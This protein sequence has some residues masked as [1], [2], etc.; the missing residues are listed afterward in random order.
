MQTFYWNLHAF[1]FVILGVHGV[2]GYK[3]DCRIGRLTCVNAMI[4]TDR[5]PLNGNITDFLV[6]GPYMFATQHNEVGFLYSL[7]LW[8]SQNTALTKSAKGVAKFLFK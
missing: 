3:L 8:S 7:T 4:L 6:K 1:I 2:Q 5:A